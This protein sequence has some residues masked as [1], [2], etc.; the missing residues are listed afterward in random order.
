MSAEETNKKTVREFTRIFKNEHNVHGVA[1]LFAK[2]F[3]HHFKMPL[4]DGLAGFQAIGSV[5]NGAF[6]DVEVSEKDLIAA[7]DRVIERS[8]VVGTHRGDFMGIPATNRRVSWSEIHIYR[9]E[10]GKIAE[11]WVE[12]SMLELMQQLGAAHA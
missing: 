4:P 5:M 11:H 8:E 10:D 3:R 12:L 9:L 1:H 6:P 7:G 2:N